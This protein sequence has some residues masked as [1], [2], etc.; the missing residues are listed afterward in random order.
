MKQE[1]G[2]LELLT[3]QKKKKK[4]SAGLRQWIPRYWFEPRASTRITAL[5]TCVEVST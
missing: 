2:A 1:K 5:K 3:K 4:K